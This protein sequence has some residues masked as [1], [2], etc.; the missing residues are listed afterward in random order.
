MEHRFYPESWK[1]HDSFFSFQGNALGENTETWGRGRHFTLHLITNSVSQQP[2]CGQPASGV[3]IPAQWNGRFTGICESAWIIRYKNIACLPH[4]V[5][6]DAGGQGI[7]TG[8]GEPEMKERAEPS[9][10]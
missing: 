6:D 5:S 2:D 1:A 4:T 9:P 10:V 7:N 3:P 8:A